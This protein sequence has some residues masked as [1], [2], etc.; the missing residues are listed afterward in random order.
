MNG[1]RLTDLG[2]LLAF[3]TR[4]ANCNVCGSGLTV[5]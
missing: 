4:Q 1:L 5:R 3:V 2:D